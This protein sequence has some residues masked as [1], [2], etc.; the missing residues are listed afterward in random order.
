MYLTRT[1]L[2]I[3]DLFFLA[4]LGFAVWAI[5]NSKQNVLAIDIVTLVLLARSIFFHIRWYKT[6]GKLY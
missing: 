3:G 2:I 4:A 6:T 5:F 1:R